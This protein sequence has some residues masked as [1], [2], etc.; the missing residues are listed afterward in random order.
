MDQV[1]CDTE[2]PSFGLKSKGSYCCIVSYVRAEPLVPLH[3]SAWILEHHDA[4]YRFLVLD[5]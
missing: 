1:V 4:V 3:F 5:C 2:R